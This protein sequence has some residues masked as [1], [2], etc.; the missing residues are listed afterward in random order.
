MATTANGRK[1]VMG[2]GGI[3]PWSLI[4]LLLFIIIPLLIF[5]P[6]ALKAGYS[7]WWSLVMIIP[8]VNLVMIWVFAII[9]WPIDK[10]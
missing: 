6:I 7:G 3:S 2:I 9:E 1:I 5:R 10:K 8:I 4:I